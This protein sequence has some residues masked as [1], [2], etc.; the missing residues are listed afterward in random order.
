MLADK[1]FTKLQEDFTPHGVQ[2]TTPHFLYN[3]QFEV[4]ERALNKRVSNLR[5]HVERAI[6]RVK[7]FKILSHEMP[8]AQLC[9]AEQIHYVCCFLTSFMDPL[10]HVNDI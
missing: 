9:N 4:D 5:C 7:N 2:I 1:G 3:K 6:G 8:I 10:I